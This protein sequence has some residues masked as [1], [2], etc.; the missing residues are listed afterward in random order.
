MFT[1]RNILTLLDHLDWI[2]LHW[3]WAYSRTAAQAT[4]AGGGIQK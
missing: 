4:G 1:Q 2:N 3:L